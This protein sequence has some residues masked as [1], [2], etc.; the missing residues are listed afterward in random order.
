MIELKKQTAGQKAGFEGT[1]QFKETRDPNQLCFSFNQRTLIY[2]AVDEL[3]AFMTTRLDKSATKFLPFNKGD[4]EAAGNPIV[5]GKHSTYYLWEEILQKDMLLRIIRE[6]MFI[7]DG[8][9]MIFPR[10]HQLRA[11]L[12][13]EE[14]SKNTGVG[15][16]SD[17]A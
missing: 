9:N 11:V 1:K 6:F 13:I 8:G 14:D 17:M 15:E 4:N 5:E 3:V 10:Y 7:D 12:R 2:F 16:I